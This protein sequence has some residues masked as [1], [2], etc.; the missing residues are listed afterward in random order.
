MRLKAQIIMAYSSER[1]TA[2]G[3]P[4]KLKMRLFT[5]FPWKNEYLKHKN[6]PLDWNQQCYC[7]T[8]T[9]PLP[10]CPVPVPLNF[11]ADRSHLRIV[12]PPAFPLHINKPTPKISIASLSTL[13]AIVKAT[14]KSKKIPKLTII[15]ATLNLIRTCHLL[16]YFTIPNPRNQKPRNWRNRRHSNRES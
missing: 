3:W 12:E 5:P 1:A 13:Q 8:G 15:K 4:A 6:Q 7:L 10:N 14:T 16:T 2:T 9:P 11:H